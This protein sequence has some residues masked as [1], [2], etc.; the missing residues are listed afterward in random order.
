M[1]YV[2]F[3]CIGRGVFLH[4]RPG[5]RG[6]AIIFRTFI[7]MIQFD[8]KSV[9]QALQR[10]SQE[11]SRYS[12]DK[13]NQAISLAL[14]RAA[15]SGRTEGNSE[16]R[17]RYNLAASVINSKFRVHNSNRRNLT[18]IISVS[19]PPLSLNYFQAKQEGPKL[20]RTFDRRG[21]ALTR[22]NRRTRIAGKQGVTV[23]IRKGETLNIPDAF[24]QTA[25][26]GT[27]VFARGKYRGTGEGFE[28]MKERLPIGKLTT[29]SV[30]LMMSNKDVL[31][32]TDKRI[33]E[34]LE[35]RIVHEF[36]RVMRI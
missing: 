1:L 2:F 12:P 19:S 20:T 24:I 32:A 3:R 10:I 25:N 29:T 17:K 26:G 22:L 6:S 4:G 5:R 30:P 23:T 11:Y 8:G 28:F 15:V 36:R 16:I 13:M 18:A 27:T 33:T 7:H 21:S 9:Q 35:D 14:N 31:R 34:V